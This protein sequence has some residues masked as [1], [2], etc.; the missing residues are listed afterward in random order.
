MVGELWPQP[1]LRA[2]YHLSDTSDSSGNSKTLTNTNTVLFNT[3]KFGLGAD[4]GSTNTNKRLSTTDTLS[5]DGNICTIMGWYKITGSTFPMVLFQHSNNTSK[6]F[7]RI[8]FDNSTTCIG[9]RAN[10]GSS[11]TDLSV[12]FSPTGF[13][14]Y[15]LTYDNT[16]LRFYINGKK[17]ASGAASGTGSAA[18]TSGFVIGGNES[19]GLVLQGIS[20]EVAVFT[21]VLT[22]R[23]IANYYQWSLGRFAKIL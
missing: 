8:Y 1:N 4:G 11:S 2:L 22:E 10:F 15:A 12:T 9:Q 5:I 18:I 14:H 13:N 17:V 7:F 23:E 21:K 16:T 19:G 6:T 3:A 20:D